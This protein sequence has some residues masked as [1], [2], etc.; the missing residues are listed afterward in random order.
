LSLVASLERVAEHAAREADETG[1]ALEHPVQEGEPER[2]VAARCHGGNLGDKVRA[3]V[4]AQLAGAEVDRAGR[5]V[6]EPG[7]SVPVLGAGG[8]PAIGAGEPDDGVDGL[9]AGDGR[10]ELGVTAGLADLGGS[11]ACDGAGEVVGLQRLVGAP[12]LPVPAQPAA[13]EMD[14]AQVVGVLGGEAQRQ[15]LVGIFDGPVDG[16]GRP[17]H[18]PAALHHLVEEVVNVSHRRAPPD[19]ATGPGARCWRRW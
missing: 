7:I 17:V 13:P 15:R 18:R 12:A 10:G 19:G 1:I 5:R 4:R 8:V 6:E 9:G 11:G 16:L 2:A 14:V 3:F